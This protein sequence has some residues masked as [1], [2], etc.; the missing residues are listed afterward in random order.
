MTDNSDQSVLSI[1]S[2]FPNFQKD[3]SDAVLLALKP[4]ATKKVLNCEMDCFNKLS[5]SL[6][7]TRDLSVGMQIC[8]THI[9]AKVSEPR[10]IP[11]DRLYDIL[12]LHV[13]KDVQ[14]DNLVSFDYLKEFS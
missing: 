2:Q 4:I 10:G 13:I 1:L 8:E 3:D 5:K 6:V 12:G 9:C 11:A 7:F 14:K